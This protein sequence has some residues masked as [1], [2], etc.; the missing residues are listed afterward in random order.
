MV[1]KFRR[2]LIDDIHRP[3][4]WEECETPEPLPR[5]LVDTTIHELVRLLPLPLQRFPV[6]DRLPYHPVAYSTDS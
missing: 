2:S 3:C 6:D 1:N 5:T 4:S